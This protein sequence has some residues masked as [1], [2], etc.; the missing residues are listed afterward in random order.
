MKNL[1]KKPSCFTVMR[2]HIPATALPRTRQDL[3]QFFQLRNYS[4]KSI[5]TLTHAQIRIL[6]RFIAI[7]YI[8]ELL[9]KLYCDID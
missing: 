2:L 3:G 7:Y 5:H 6:E 9:D 4:T 1:T 8:T